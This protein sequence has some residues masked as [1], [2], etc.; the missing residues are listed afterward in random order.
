MSVISLAVQQVGYQSPDGY[1]KF[2][3]QLDAV[4]YFNGKKTALTGVLYL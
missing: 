4:D 2:A 1:N 3:E